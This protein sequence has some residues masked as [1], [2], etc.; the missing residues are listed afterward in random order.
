[1][2]NVSVAGNVLRTRH[3]PWMLIVPYSS[4]VVILSIFSFL[5]LLAFLEHSSSTK[6][7][8]S[9]VRKNVEIMCEEKA[10]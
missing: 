4:V 5:L 1:M 7:F 2:L 10:S 8:A 3:V 6:V 9:T